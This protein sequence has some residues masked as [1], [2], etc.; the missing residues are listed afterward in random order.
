MLFNEKI[1]NNKKIEKKDPKN[2]NLIIF[3]FFFGSKM[4]F[5]HINTKNKISKYADG[6]CLDKKEVNRITGTKNQ[7][8]G[9]CSLNAN[10]IKVTAIIENI[11]A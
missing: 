11:T 9:L 10:I 6:I 8:N 4:I 1:K 7:Y 2:K 5:I 3:K